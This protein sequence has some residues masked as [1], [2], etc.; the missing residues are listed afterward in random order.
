MRQ[1]FAKGLN[2]QSLSLSMV[3]RREKKALCFADNS[4]SG[5]LN[6]ML[7]VEAIAL[8]KQSNQYIIKS[9]YI[10]TFKQIKVQF[11]DFR[12]GNWE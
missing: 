5:A 4:I 1:D 10:K 7:K 9:R 3:Q 8:N 2:K 11:L 6:V 12:D